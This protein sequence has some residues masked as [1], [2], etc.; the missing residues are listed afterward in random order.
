MKLVIV[1]GV[2][3][4][5]SCAARARRLDENAEIVVLERGEH[6][7]FANCGLPYHIGGAI[8]E[9]ARLLLQTPD[10]LRRMLNL[11][12]RVG[13]EVVSIDRKAKT[14][15]V[16]ELGSG[17][18][19]DEGYEKLVLAPGAAPLR[20]NLPGVDHERV[21]VLR[22]VGDMDR[23]KTVV[24]DGATSAVV[25]GG[26]YIGIEM[27]D[28]LKEAGLEVDLVEMADQL[29]TPL[30]PEMAR[31]LELHARGHGLRL[32]LGAAAAAFAESGSKVRVELVDGEMLTA[33]F[34]IMAAGVK[35]E[36][37][38]AINAGLEMGERGGIRVDEHLRTSDPD[39]YSGGDVVEVTDHVMGTAAQIP[40]AGPANR[41]GRAMA[42]NIC[43]GDSIYTTTKGTAVVKVFE[44]TG[45][46]TGASEKRLKAAV[47]RYNKLYIHPSGHAGYY[48][49]T[50]TMHVKVLFDPDS[51]VL[52]GAQVV[53][54][55]GVDKR[56]DVFATALSAG[57]TVQDLQHLELSYAP[58]YGS[59]KDPVNMA[60]FVGSNMMAGLV[61]VWHAEDY[62]EQTNSG[63]LI[64]VRNKSEY[65]VWHIPGA[66]LVPLARLR[67]SLEEI[68]KS[69]PVFVYCKVGFRS[70]LAQRILKQ[71]GFDVRTLS[72]GT[73]TFCQVHRAG[74]CPAAAEPP[75]VSYAEDKGTGEPAPSGQRVDLDLRG[76][77]CP[78]PIRQLAAA[79]ADARSGDEVSAVASD[80]GFAT[81][82]PLWC[83]S[84]GH[85]L[86]S[87][88]PRG[89]ETEAVIRKGAPLTDSCPASTAKKKTMVVFSGDLD[90]VLAAFII[91]NGATT[92]GN[93]MTLFFTFWGLN[94]LRKSGPQAGGKG[95]LDRMFGMMMPKGA[96]RLKLSNMNMLGAGTAMMK[97]VMRTKNVD[98]LPELMQQAMDAG[99][100]IVAC[101]MSMDVMGIKREELIDGI[102]IGGVA[103]FL[104][105]SDEANMTLFV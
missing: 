87:L 74:I 91:A 49:G 66:R 36:S 57:M 26:G 50:A 55:D 2:A 99:V 6:V 42:D 67:A 72:G 71:H 80:P 79:L 77:Q 3:A 53:G 89:A 95:L 102:E 44:M 51:G 37:Q 69:K 27:A 8:K 75:V 61:D 54:Y 92:M 46:A 17:R 1:G 100:K 23:I 12:V 24:D 5:M 7:S 48:P 38:L 86:V 30:D 41:Q 104:G 33:D 81:D 68:D 73:M 19:Y 32:H 64:D 63:Q 85:T 62:P 56:L 18:E 13:Q 82:M 93:E 15:R 9:R 58:P 39:V 60:G 83:R 28:N 31:P 43:G 98:S 101:S 16:R 45:G 59:A 96:R 70:Y 105:A 84:S 97:H 25:I 94:A 88:T 11:D 103:H 78:G 21:F 14:V 34:V 76:L 22:N 40:L 52:L 4:G 90:K 20:P 35:P 29:M 10:S 47:R 65:D